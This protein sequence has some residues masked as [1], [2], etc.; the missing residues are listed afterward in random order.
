MIAPVLK[1]GRPKGLV[2]SNLTP[3]AETFFSELTAFFSELEWA[4]RNNGIDTPYRCLQSRARAKSV[5]R[6][7]RAPPD[8]LSAG[9][10]VSERLAHTTEIFRKLFRNFS[11]YHPLQKI[12][13]L[14]PPYEKST[15]SPLV[16]RRL[17]RGRHQFHRHGRNYC[18]ST[19]TSQ[20]QH[21][22][23]RPDWRQRGDWR[24]LCRR[25]G[26]KERHDSGAGSRAY[27]VWHS[28]CIG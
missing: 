6:P 8:P 15:S 18:C 25:T 26:T 10:A 3:S 24:L 20:Y 4:T 21:A 17:F 5:R 12:R 7:P 27:S 19:N 14:D 23:F 2:S 22:R 28:Q 16:A 1:T 13:N 11:E 9:L